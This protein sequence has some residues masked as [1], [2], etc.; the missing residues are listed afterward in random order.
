MSLKP[1]VTLPNPVL[2]QKSKPV[3]KINK[4]VE[5]LIEQMI[6]STLDWEQGRKHEI[7]V[8]MAAVQIG[9]LSRVIIIRQHPEEPGK[10]KFEV[11]INP[12]IIRTKG[13]Q[14]ATHEGCLS[15]PDLYAR[16]PRFN[17]VKVEA[18]DL[19]GKTIQLKASGFLARVLQHEID[20]LEGKLFIDYVAG[21]PFYKIDP[22]GKFK[23]LSKD[24]V[25]KHS[26]LR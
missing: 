12:R 15:V 26:F 8:A 20:H 9:E 13:A 4:D 19:E 18:Q 3:T 17:Q 24:E 2:R 1:I 25:S 21:K 22:R 5:Q 16:V 11:L 23:P 7:G 14:V 10:A 6:A